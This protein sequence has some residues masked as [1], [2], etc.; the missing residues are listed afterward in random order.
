MSGAKYLSRNLWFAV[1]M[2]CV[3]G[4]A[5]AIPQK[6]AAAEKL[7]VGINLTT[8]ETLPIYLA[9]DEGI[10]LTGGALPL[11][12][13]G[14]ADAVTNAETQ[15]LLRSTANPDI[16]VILTVAEYSYRIVARRSAGIATASDLRGKKI[17]T[18]LNSSAHFYIV[19]TLREAGLAE[20]D[21]SIVGLPPPDMPGA[22]ARGDVDAVSIWEPASEKSLQALG[23]D[24]VIIRGPRYS[25]R[26]NL[27][28]TSEIAADPVKRAALVELLRGIIRT[29]KEVRD[30]P[31]KVQP[32]IAGKLD[33]PLPLV[34]ETWSLFRFPA[35]IPD[36]LLATMVEQEPWMAMKQNR[37]P[38]PREA[39]A[40]L[41]DASLWQEAAR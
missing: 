26:F 30:H 2:A 1:A 11:L 31:D 24:T 3:C 23:P 21:V 22:L 13:A 15:A 41:I 5:I 4:S 32:V 38:R 16:R 10:E 7:R 6:A 14:K 28:T 29:S 19:K 17:A 34:S 33:L 9:A 27:N 40:A 25:E 35:A 20:A 12:T 8:I 36:D 18:S 37:A 39:I